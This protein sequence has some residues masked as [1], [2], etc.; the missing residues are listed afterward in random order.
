[1]SDDDGANWHH[2]HNKNG[3]PSWSIV[4]LHA[5]CM[6]EGQV[7]EPQC[8]SVCCVLVSPQTT[9]GPLVG[10][11][12]LKHVLQ[13]NVWDFVHFFRSIMHAICALH[14]QCTHE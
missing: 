13:K 9:H 8:L 5:W 11:S 14:E 10:V 6:R 2:G 4:F 7:R 1:M 12:I 3:S